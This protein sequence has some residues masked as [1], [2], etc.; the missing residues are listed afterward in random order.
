VRRAARA[1]VACGALLALGASCGPVVG[2]PLS[3]APLNRCGGATTCASFGEAAQCLDGICNQ[4]GNVVP[5]FVSF[6]VV[7]VPDTSIYAAG[8]TFLLPRSAIVPSTSGQSR[9]CLPPCVQLPS[10]SNVVGTYR[11]T[12]QAA[13]DV[14]F[15][16]LLPEGASLPVR[17][18]YTLLLGPQGP[19]A[20]S[21]A[22]PVSS[23]MTLSRFFKKENAPDVVLEA[24]SAVQLGS[25][26]RVASPEPPYDEY[27]PPVTASIGATTFADD[28]LVGAA[29]APLDSPSGEYRRVTVRRSQGLEGYKVWLADSVSRQRISSL[30]PLSGVE[31]TVRL[32]TVGQNV[33]GSSALRDGV[34]LIAAPPAGWLGVPSY[35]ASA[36]A[37]VVELPRIDFPT[38]PAP[39]SVSGFVA[40]ADGGLFKGVASKVHLE[41]QSVRDVDGT[42]WPQ[43]NYRTT[44]AS[45][46]SGGF[47]TVIPPGTYDVVVEPAE[48]TGFAKGRQ[49]T[50]EITQSRSDLRLSPLPRSE[51]VGRA[52]LADGRPLA[53]AEVFANPSTS[54]PAG[55]L[56]PRPGHVRVAD[57]GTF[58]MELD[59]GPYDFAVDPEAG[60]G[61]PRAISIR[62]IGSGRSDLGDIAV[63]PPTVVSMTFQAP[64]AD[65]VILIPRAIVRVYAQA[66][67]SR[68]AGSGSG[69]GAFVEIGQG[70]T[71]ANGSCEI[72]LAPRA[73]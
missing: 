39:V 62:S 72:L 58:R 68:G 66:G 53:G 65:V 33:A 35:R 67:A 36:K 38:F 18:F 34:D 1:I 17:A 11:V 31:S 14:G 37:F 4:G 59:P 25:Y 43:F 42:D 28:T 26:A 64:N 19:T 61:F 3:R 51:V 49:P 10:L 2:Q 44:V 7:H 13:L 21:L 8:K 56:A 15:P 48:G 55:I 47:A 23:S 29:T 5:S 6:V 45:D 57:D 9:N 32:D 63:D 70:M 73:P 12:T 60:S 54:L 52:V 22:L 71:D 46:D 27:F 24:R 30:R 40:V 20:E 50:L 16:Q 41:S 69:T